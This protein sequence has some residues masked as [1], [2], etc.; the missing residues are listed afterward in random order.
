[1]KPTWLISRRRALRGT[2][3]LIALPFLEAM[4]APGRAQAAG[5]P[6]RF[7]GWFHPNGYNID[8]WQ[9]AAEGPGFTSMPSLEPLTPVKDYVIVLS[10]MQQGG[11]MIGSHAEGLRA[12]FTAAL[13]GGTSI[14][15]VIAQKTKA[16]TRLPSL[17]LS[18]EINGDYDPISDKNMDGL[19][20]S[21]TSEFDD[22]KD[23]CADDACRASFLNGTLLPNYTNPRLVFERLFAGAGA[24]TGGS[25]VMVDT[26]ALKRRNALKKNLLDFVVDDTKRLQSRLGSS[27]KARLEEY[28]T[29]ISE[30]DRA[31]SKSEQ[32]M[33]AGCAPGG[34][35]AG[36]PIDL[37]AR[38]K[39]FADLIVKAFQCDSTRS[40]TMML[41]RHTSNMRFQINGQGVS[42]HDASH[43]A[44][45]DGKRKSKE[46]I[47]RWMVKQ[48]AYL[49][50]AL[51]KVPE[52]TGTMLDNVVAFASS[53][54]GDPNIHDQ[55]KMPV[56]LG[57]RAGGAFKTGR[58]MKA[59]GRQIGDLFI[60]I[61]QAFGIEQAKFGEWG[62]K[63][64]A[65]LG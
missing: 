35:P 63:P 62:T 28:L 58:H 37:E 21:P 24:T 50:E 40:I 39:L 11:G 2:G 13:R 17:Q 6:L 53:D 33:A 61:L 59:D 42:H 34:K 45:D 16:M 18:L 7:I 3:A 20:D 22:T 19:I 32:P 46:F 36:M 49:L 10:G 12:L 48:F 25:T 1:M 41:G 65:G 27:D 55:L 14:D 8:K 38:M 9:P 5:G 54:I 30:I 23:Y 56:L 43:W 57:G 15:Q 52:G 31:L 60:T 47:D 64:L 44:G 4:V 26:A 51:A 29:G